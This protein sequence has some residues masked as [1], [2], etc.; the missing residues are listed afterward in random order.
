MRQILQILILVMLIATSAIAQENSRIP[1]PALQHEMTPDEL[2]RK[3]EIGRGFVETDP[4]FAPIRN[5]AEFDRMQGALVRYPFGI[6]IS[7]IKEMAIDVTVTTIVAS[8]AQ[9]NTV[10]SQ[11]VANGVDTSHCN[12][13][14][15]PSDSY[16]TRDYGPWFESDSSDQ[17]GIVDFPYNRPRPNDDEIP[18]KV[19]A[20]LGIPWYGMNVIS[21]GGDY[22]TDGFGIS[23]STDLVWVENPSLTHAQIAQKMSDYLGISNYQVVPDP[24]ISTTIDHIDCWGKFLAPDKILIRK[25]LTSDPEYTALESA[26]TYWG[27]QICSFGYNYKVYRVMTPQDQPYSNSVILNNKVLVPFMNSSWD[28]SAKAVYEAAMPGYQVIG[29]IGNPSTPWISTD[30]LHCRVMGIADIGLLHIKHIPINGNQP[31]EYDYIVNAEIIASSHQPVTSDSALIHYQ[32]NGGLYH[33]ALMIHSTG[34]HYSGVIPKQAAGSVI[35]YYL[36]AADQSGRHASAPLIGAADPYT[37]HTIYTNLTPVPDTVWVNTISEGRQIIQLHNFMASAISLNAVQQF[38]T[39]IPWW[40][41]SM[42]VA[43]LPHL[44]NPGDSFAVRITMAFPL[45]LNPVIEYAIDSMRVTTDAGS[46]HV[47][48]M[49]NKALLT[50][51][52]EP[53]RHVEIG[54]N[55][56]NPFST[57]T[58]IPLEI[59][60]RSSISIEIL[61]IRGAKVKTLVSQVFEPG[62]IT[63]QWDGTDYHGNKLPSGIYLYRLITESNI[64]TKR[65]IF[66]KD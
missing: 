17:I 23:A 28:D 32:V 51:I 56:P 41:D 5:V 36:T 63:I 64:Q 10:I 62:T 55:Y 44:V 37:F 60:Q 52:N 38:G 57:V 49:V 22:M 26:A 42:S 40:V 25:V 33:T 65:L 2:L 58:T 13:L 48:I 18:K 39:S 50:S 31:C 59:N 21:T 11:Y 61:D 35:K 45:S 46:F 1:R 16:W 19:A 54:N 30:A 43:V 27:S 3:S 20:M 4:P 15:A 12:F 14:I 6:P 9:Q 8:T 7:L 47:I 34:N 53:V 66:I 24:N 29:F